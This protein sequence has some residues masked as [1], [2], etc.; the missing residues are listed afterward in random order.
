GNALAD[1][2]SEGPRR[3][4]LHRQVGIVAGES[5]V[6][7]LR[8]VFVL[9]AGNELVLAHE[10]LEKARVLAQSAIEHLQRDM[11]P[12]VLALGEVY[13]RL[14]ALPDQVQHEVAGEVLLRPSGCSRRGGDR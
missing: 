3:Q 6:V 14:A 5:L 2:R 7:D 8:D 13:L 10:A 12:V 11:Q 4:E 1:A 9:E